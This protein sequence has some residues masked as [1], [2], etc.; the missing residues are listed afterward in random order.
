M[1]MGMRQGGG[2]PHRIWPTAAAR[3]RP[4]GCLGT[5]SP[6]AIESLPS[7]LPRPF[8]TGERA[9]W[10]GQGIMPAALPIAVGDV[11]WEGPAGRSKELWRLAVWGHTHLE[12]TN[13]LSLACFSSKIQHDTKNSQTLK[14][15]KYIHTTLPDSLE[16][17]F[18]V[19]DTRRLIVSRAPMDPL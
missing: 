7:I 11:A 14:S 15:M 12:G 4:E 8:L 13:L 5:I 1:S 6:G 16:G 10:D 2:P 19:C 17:D 9:T 3:G 18:P